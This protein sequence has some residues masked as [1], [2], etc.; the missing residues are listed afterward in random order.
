MV[1]PP[2]LDMD[3]IPRE[4]VS[5]RA[6]LYSKG[7]HA[8]CIGFMSALHKDSFQASEGC[9]LD[10]ECEAKV[11]FAYNHNLDIDS[12]VNGHHEQINHFFDYM[13]DYE[14]AMMDEDG[15][16]SDASDDSHGDTI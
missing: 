13:D 9:Y 6:C 16:D 12:W 10:V 15:F 4:V 2:V 1:N 5:V 11:K 8:L 14:A 7:S 3:A